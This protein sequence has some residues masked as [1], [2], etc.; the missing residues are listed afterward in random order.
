M[1][2]EDYFSLDQADSLEPTPVAGKHNRNLSSIVSTIRDD[3]PS[4]LE[5]PPSPVDVEDEPAPV[6][7]TPDS[8][9]QRIRAVPGTKVMLKVAGALLAVL[10]LGMAMLIAKGQYPA[11]DERGLHLADL[12]TGFAEEL[13]DMKHAT[14]TRLAQWVDQAGIW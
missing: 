8:H 10:L 5:L 2:A 4:A 12:P 13:V 9:R 3:G 11:I 1:I 7:G 14:Q 6:I